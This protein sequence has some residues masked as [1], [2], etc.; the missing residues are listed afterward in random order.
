M[1]TEKNRWL[2][3]ET[4]LTVVVGLAHTGAGILLSYLFLFGHIYYEQRQ[5][6][7]SQTSITRIQN[8]QVRTKQSPTIEEQKRS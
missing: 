2:F 4:T 7:P 8:Q 1:L 3:L 6:P 5:V